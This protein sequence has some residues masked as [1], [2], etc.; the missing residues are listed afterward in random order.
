[1]T[2][3]KKWTRLVGLLLFLF[4][5]IWL[6]S[7]ASGPTPESAE[8]QQAIQAFAPVDIGDRDAIGEIVETTISLPTTVNL[9]D[10]PA[11]VYDPNNQYDR[12]QRGEIDLQ[13][14]FF[15]LPE[16]QMALL[17]AEALTLPSSENVQIAPTGPAALAP[18]SGV[19]F[20]SM[21]YTEC[22]GGGGNVPP[23]PELAVGPNHV[24]AVVNVAFEIYDKSG[25][26]LVGPTTFAS[27]MGSNTNCTGVFDPNALYDEREDRYILGID[28][29]GTDYCLAVSQTSDPTGSWNIYSFS[30]GSASIFFDYPHAG[31]G[32]D[33]IYMGANMF[34]NTTSSF[35]D[36]RIWAFNKAQMYAGQAATSV[37][38]NLG[39]ND[40]TPQPLNLHGWNQGTWPTSGP[41]YFIAE[42]GYNG[43]NH[44][45][46]SWSNPFGS[47]TFS[48]VGVANLNTA[49][50][51]T[52]A[53]T[54]SFPQASGG[55]LQ[56]NDWRPQDFEYRNGF[57]WTTMAIGCNPG[58]GTVNCVRWAQINPAT[59]AVV[60]A[61][62]YSSNGE[63]RQFPDL[64]VNHCN[65]MAV[66]YTKSSSSIFPSVYV[67][68]RQSTDPA[69][70]LQAEVLL[71]SGEISYTSFE[72]T[73]PR[74]WGDYT[75]MTIDPNGTTFWYL[76]EYSKNTGTTSGRWGTYIG[77]YSFGSCTTG[78][79]P[80]PGPTATATNTP[81]PTNTPVPGTCTVYN[82]TDVPKTISTSGTPSVSSVLSISGSGT[83][84][85]IN[86]LNLN[87]THTWINDLDF[88]LTS[89][90]GTE[91]QIMARSCS[92]QDN[93]N[94]NLDDEAAPGSWPCPPT[95]G[96]TYQPSSP[97]SAFD[98]QSAN[99]TWTLRV[100][101]NAN[102]DGGSLNGWSLEV[103]TVGI[104]ATA[105]N[106]PIPPTATNTPL[107]TN[108]SV[109]PTATNTPTNTPIPPTPTNTLVP[110]NTS[111]PPTATNTPVP[112]NTSVPPT[113]T[114]T[115]VPPTPT[116]TPQP[117]TGEVIYV[118]SSSNGSVGGVSFADEDILAYNT[119]T[120][121]WSLFMDGS[122]VGLGG[123]SAQDTAAFSFLPDGSI[124]LS[125]V[126]PTSITGIGSVD[127]S[128]IVR[129]IPTSTGSNTAGT[130]EFYFDGSDVGLTQNSEDIDAVSVLSD[131]RLV[132]STAGS[133][134]VPGV[135]G[136]QDE[137]LIIFT[138]TSLGSTT[139]GTW[140]ALFDGSDVGLST[141]SSEDVWGAWIDETTGDLY[142]TTRGSFSVSGVSGD[143]ADIFVCTP[144][145]LGTTTACSFSM[146]WDG[147][148]F[149]FGGE[150]MD[151]F[152]IVR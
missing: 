3:W 26:S 57:A 66:G 82:S 70:T 99:G 71:K 34:N 114:N 113:A 32:N 86:V 123:S 72:A 65:D 20:A 1:M 42:T 150:A 6:L 75:E 124:L 135:S 95:D 56:G 119:T 31:V 101:D 118:S 44:T 83:I 127:D 105:T 104:P 80:T 140:A 68:G 98:G 84:D 46:Y 47:N 69:G 112:T 137:D 40:D 49:T 88:N 97:L 122:D 91:V 38:R 81:L 125:F 48:T 41:H 89:P 37:M 145:S 148:A 109:P 90:G 9:A 139:S 74:R 126:S 50:G 22:C 23:D 79:T 67:T 14:E 36:S 94:I 24:I 117:G 52:A 11:G 92:S 134:S 2:S 63:Y 85:D 58:S 29:N 129:F 17:Q 142:L 30:T 7:L 10:V 132:I 27:F 33:A 102:L 107:P 43:A 146:Y 144:S 130:F 136:I 96:G 60:N 15:R 108:T 61:G 87:G 138:P 25:N 111:V 93:F 120:G 103:C 121:T 19:S 12:W 45:I 100:D 143:G 8:R 39:A 152:R 128:D 73:A 116:N 53:N 59:A 21:D 77:S 106:T 141:S 51:V 18:T 133:A 4:C 110:T 28:A 147:S 5:G 64:A 78:P 16:S 76:G 13:E 55:T 131:G 151:G 35:M 54:V 115:P 62:V 149:G